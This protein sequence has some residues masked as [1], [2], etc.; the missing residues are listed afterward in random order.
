MV[1]VDFALL[2]RPIP[3]A[4]KV[5]FFDKK[6]QKPYQ[7]EVFARTALTP[8]CEGFVPQDADEHEEAGD[9][10]Q[11]Q[12]ARVVEADDAGRVLLARAFGLLVPA[13]LQFN[14]QIIIRPSCQFQ[15]EEHGIATGA[16]SSIFHGERFEFR[17]E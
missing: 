7:P 11:V 14:Y 15:H 16:N 8:L 1:S 3:P 5:F 13:T 17:S 9:L 4:I 6:G 2:N 10:S 12:D